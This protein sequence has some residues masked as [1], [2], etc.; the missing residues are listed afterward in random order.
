MC[1]SLYLIGLLLILLNLA[2]IGD[3]SFNRTSL[4]CIWDRMTTYYYTVS[5]TVI[6]VWVPLIVTGIFY[7][8]IF[9]KCRASTKRISHSTTTGL[10]GIT[11]GRCISQSPYSW[12][13]QPS[14][15]VGFPTQ[16]SWL[17]TGMTHF[18][19]RFTWSLRHWRTCI[20]L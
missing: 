17:P 12:S 8:L 1:V 20:L 3:H 9:I 2:G 6:F 15:F 10:Q 19:M 16:Y 11:K 14:P 18:R 7:C 13:M 4:E 5:F